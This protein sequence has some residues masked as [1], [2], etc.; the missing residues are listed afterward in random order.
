MVYDVFCVLG[1]VLTPTIY[2][3]MFQC[4]DTNGDQ[5]IDWGEWISWSYLVNY[6]TRDEKMKCNIQ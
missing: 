1:S 3:R 2:D 5:S 4:C 6:G